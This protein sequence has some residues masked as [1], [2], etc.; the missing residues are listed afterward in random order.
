MDH[1]AALH[2][3]EAPSFLLKIIPHVDAMPRICELVR[4]TLGDIAL[5]GAW[6]SPAAPELNAHALAPLTDLPVL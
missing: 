2:A 4:T 6:T 5:K 1:A 3:L